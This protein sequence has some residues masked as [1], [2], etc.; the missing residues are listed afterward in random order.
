MTKIHLISRPPSF[1]QPGSNKPELENLLATDN[2]N[3]GLVTDIDIAKIP[4]NGLSAATNVAYTKKQVFRRNG[5]T[6][7]PNA[8]P[9]ANKILGIFG[10][11][12]PVSGIVILRATKDSLHRVKISGW[13]AFAPDGIAA[14][15][16]SDVD[17]FNFVVG[18]NRCF[19]T[20]SGIDPIREV[21]PESLT[22]KALGNAPSY[23]FITAAFNRIIGANLYVAGAPSNPVEVGWSGDRN[24]GVWDPV[25]DIS[26]GLTPLVDS[27]SDTSDDITNIF[28]TTNLLIVPRVKTIWVGV[29][30]PSATAPFRF[31]PA[32]K[33]GADIPRAIKLTDY[34]LVWFN[35]QT[36]S[37]YAWAPGQDA[38]ADEIEFSSK[39]RRAIKAD[40]KRADLITS[41]YSSDTRTFSIAM[42]S[43]STGEV[44]IWG[45]NFLEKCWARDTAVD[46]CTIADLDFEGAS[47]TIDD[48]S[49][50]IDDLEGSID[51]LGQGIAKITRFLGYTDGEIQTYRPYHGYPE[52]PDSDIKIQDNAT[53][54]T[55]VIGYKLVEAPVDYLFANLV[56][57][58]IT[59]YSTGSVSLEYSKNDGKTWTVAK[60]KTFIE[61]ELKQ[62]FHLQLKRALRFKRIIWRITTSDCMCANN[63][64]YIKALRAGTA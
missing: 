62:Q 60:T 10:F 52:S 38:K 3:E 35:S 47:L 33:V 8:K 11:L 58:A 4:D 30:Q 45:Y 57:C 39:V 21:V 64:F 34:G 17:Y 41:S 54:F 24:Y 36:G 37:A 18:D 26:S 55:T 46:L 32:L 23:R 59:P 25:S 15:S 7:W 14:F 56:R 42:S 53:S 2:F 31:V 49:G 43:P 44:V 29:N 61:A 40:V 48:L 63:G 13:D 51:E 12:H 28:S 50:P 20:N 27:P 6:I 19:V 1:E 9:N 5:T 22:Y 16:G